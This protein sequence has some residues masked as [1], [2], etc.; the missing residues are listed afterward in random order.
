MRSRTREDE[1][2]LAYRYWLGVA[3]PRAGNKRRR[4]LDRKGLCSRHCYRDI[5]ALVTELGLVTH[6]MR[7]VSR[8]R[9]TH[10]RI[11]R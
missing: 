1:T 6:G 4:R 9:G 11:A 7:W 8:R 5:E 10:R 3:Y 2:L